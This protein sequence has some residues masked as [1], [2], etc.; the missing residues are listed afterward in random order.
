MS[1]APP[2]GPPIEVM[3]TYKE[4][5]LKEP[6]DVTPER[7]KANYEKYQAEFKERAAKSFF[8]RH[9]QDEW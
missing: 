5:L 2:R 3:L 6:D 7:S 1:R 9:Y 4:F 8:E